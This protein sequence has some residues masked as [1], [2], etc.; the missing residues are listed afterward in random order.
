MSHTTALSRKR[1][2][3]LELPETTIDLPSEEERKEFVKRFD[4]E[5]TEADIV[6]IKI[7]ERTVPFSKAMI[8]KYPKLLDPNTRFLLEPIEPLICLIYGYPPEAIPENLIND[9][10]EKTKFLFGCE[11]LGI[12][13]SDEFILHL[14]TKLSQ[15]L[16]ESCDYIKRS[17]GRK[18]HKFMRLMKSKEIFDFCWSFRK[19]FADSGSSLSPEDVLRGLESDTAG[20]KIKELVVEDWKTNNLI[21]GFIKKFLSKFLGKGA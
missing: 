2:L 16:R 5:T 6:E 4:D 3:K 19:L 18:G 9:N 13:L 8:E 11:H 20:E 17:V 15:D 10:S 7:G 21:T 12:K 1:E 14:S